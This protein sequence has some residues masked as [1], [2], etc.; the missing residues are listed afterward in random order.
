MRSLVIPSPQPLEPGLSSSS[1][2]ITPETGPGRR[3]RLSRGLPL[4]APG[5]YTIDIIDRF[6]R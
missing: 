6:L 5:A 2:L 3:I 1:L 4:I